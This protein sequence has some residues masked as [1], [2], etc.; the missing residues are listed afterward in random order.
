MDT[1]SRFSSGRWPSPSV[2]HNRAE[3]LSHVTRTQA[4][5]RIL[6]ERSLAFLNVAVTSVANGQRMRTGG[7]VGGKALTAHGGDQRYP[8]WWQ[9]KGKGIEYPG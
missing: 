9:G 7:R 5:T 2:T 6:R 3:A 8:E 1:S 4:H